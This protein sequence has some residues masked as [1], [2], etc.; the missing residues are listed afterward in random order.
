MDQAKNLVNLAKKFAG[1]LASPWVF[2]FQPYIFKYTGK[3][4]A[5]LYTEKNVDTFSVKIII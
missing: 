3:S 4:R 1:P 5:T 2:N